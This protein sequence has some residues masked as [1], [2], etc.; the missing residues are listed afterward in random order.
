MTLTLDMIGDY[1]SSGATGWVFEHNQEPDKVIKIM[2]AFPQVGNTVLD[3]FQY[4]NY[5]QERHIVKYNPAHNEYDHTWSVGML[6][7]PMSAKMQMYMFD[8]LMSAQRSGGSIPTGFVKLYD[9]VKTFL[10]LNFTKD[11]YAEIATQDQDHADAWEDNF[12]SVRGPG[13]RHAYIIS[14]EKLNI[15]K[16]VSGNLRP[17]KE[18][19]A[20]V[21]GYLWDNLNLVTRDTAVAGNYGYRANKELV[22]FDPIV[23]PLP[24]YEEWRPSLAPNNVYDRLRYN[25]FSY[26]FTEEPF[27][28][29]SRDEARY[30]NRAIKKIERQLS[31]NTFTTVERE[32]ESFAVEG[33]PGSELDGTSLNDWSVR[34]LMYSNSVTGNFLEDQAKFNYGLNAESMYHRDSI[35]ELY[36]RMP[37]GKEEILSRQHNF[38]LALA[39]MCGLIL[40]NKVVYE[41]GIYGPRLAD[42]YYS[43][44]LLVRHKYGEFTGND[45][46]AVRMARDN[47]LQPKGFDSGFQEEFE[48]PAPKQTKVKFPRAKADKI[49]TKVENHLR[50]MVD[51]MMACGSYR[52]GAQMIGDIDFVVIPKA[53]YT[54]PNMLPPNEGINWVGENKAQVIIDGEKVD[55]KVTTPAAWGATV[56]YFTGPADFNIKY[57]WMAKR[58]GLKLS[59]YGLFDRNTEQYLAGATETDIFTALGRPYKDPAQRQGFSKSKKKTT[60][61]AEEIRRCKECDKTTGLTTIQAGTYC[62]DCLPINLGA[63]DNYDATYGKEQA[64]IRRKLKKSIKKQNTHGTKAGQ[65]SARKSQL[66]KQKYE[67]ACERKGLRAYKGKKTSKQNDLS[68]WSKQQWGTASGKKSS[69]T[70]EP[71][72]PAGAVK[73]LKKQGLYAKATRQKRAAT[74]AG[75]QRA[76]Y[77]KDIQNVV[78]D[79]RAESEQGPICPICYNYIPNNQTPGAYP[80][81]IARYDNETEICSDCGTSE[82]LAGMMAGPEAIAE[83]ESS[84][85]TWRDYQ[86]LIMTTK[87]NIPEIMFGRGPEMEQLRELQKK[88]DGKNSEELT[89][90]MYAKRDLEYYNQPR[91]KRGGNMDEE[92]PMAINLSYQN[93]HKPFEGLGSLFGAESKDS[94]V[95]GVQRHDAHRAGLHYDL[96]LERD[97]VLKSWSIPKGMP[98]D[99]RHLA[100]ATDDHAMSWLDFDGDIPDG[101]YG[102]GKVS[103]DNK[104]TFQTVSYSPK[105]WVFYVNSGKYEGK[106]SLVHWQDNKWLISRNRD[107]SMEAEMHLLPDKGAAGWYNPQD[108]SVNVNLANQGL[109]NEALEDKYTGLFDTIA[110]EYGHQTTYDDIMEAGWNSQRTPYQIEFAAFMVQT[111]GDFARS[112]LL[113]ILHPSCYFEIISKLSS[114]PIDGWVGQAGEEGIVISDETL[115]NFFSD[116]D[117]E[118]NEDIIVQAK[119][120]VDYPQ[121]PSYHKEWLEHFI[122]YV[123]TGTVAETREFNAWYDL[124]TDK[125]RDYIKRLGGDPHPDLNRRQASKLINQLARMKRALDQIDVDKIICSN[126]NWSWK[127]SD[128]GDDP[129][130]CHKCDFDNETYHSETMNE[131]MFEKRYGWKVVAPLENNNRNNDFPISI[132]F[133]YHNYIQRYS[134]GNLF[135]SEE[136][137]VSRDYPP[138]YLCGKPAKLDVMTAVGRRQFCNNRCRGEYEGVDYGEYPSEELEHS[139][140]IVEYYPG[141]SDYDYVEESTIDI[142]CRNCDWRTSQHHQEPTHTWDSTKQSFY[143]LHPTNTL[144]VF[145]EDGDFETYEECKHDMYIIKY[146]G[147]EEYEDSLDPRSG[148][149]VV[150]CRKCNFKD[151]LDH[152]D[153]P[154][155]CSNRGQDKPK[156]FSRFFGSEYNWDDIEW[157]T[158][159]RKP[160]ED[161]Q[162]VTWEDN[163]Y[164]SATGIFYSPAG[165]IGLQLRSQQVLSPNTWSGISGFLDADETPYETVVR[166][167]HEESG[168]PLDKIKSWKYKVIWDNKVHRTYL[169]YTDTEFK[170]VVNEFKWEWDDWHWDTNEA[171]K[172]VPNLHPGMVAALE[173]IQ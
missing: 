28:V 118:N 115:D 128:G 165:R 110:H 10:P 90:E 8:E 97:G 155:G 18:V 117:L 61:K 172:Q 3:A 1:I 169:F 50:P 92:T 49:V 37:N 108:K 9:S 156:D 59:E 149:I 30:V 60:K 137:Y 122:R 94:K 77:S 107:Q 151:L 29:E 85:R 120:I 142:R 78:S 113:A 70:G 89:G 124:A 73:A 87:S 44:D 47:C 79:Y 34:D 168:L 103:L 19:F 150:G 83:W 109:R 15:S 7:R 161:W 135:G 132:N 141:F 33:F 152:V 48:A 57:R 69:V 123:D 41:I 139:L 153:I 53:G 55:F 21:A 17:R 68:N 127:R 105:K 93:Y 40:G 125:Q 88:M 43:K 134:L 13:H 166:E 121:I 145:D 133:A 23:A 160:I 144:P 100:I 154:A 147:R 63:E 56:L 58:K 99:N 114:K 6:W 171:W 82:A 146:L 27:P 24:T 72:F 4:H 66:L 42:P 143:R 158:T 91:E 74:K 164:I 45:P 162:D 80:G 65:W 54:L 76:S 20:E 148:N 86:I 101:T 31:N 39:Q 38:N 32:A 131:A 71:Y 62:Y 138:C 51:K 111:G 5:L 157:T 25:Y 126:C 163:K 119:R 2:K 129:F 95:F 112:K 67:A 170:P 116:L 98:T 26:L 159:D 81:A 16:N 136:S 173:V 167:I 84:E 102:A 14:M 52:R 106:Y 104:S 64:K 11:I 96:R 36:L 46:D 35:Y 75:K 140:E 22:I 130:V 12:L